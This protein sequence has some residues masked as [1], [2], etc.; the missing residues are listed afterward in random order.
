MGG[1][2][3]QHI[4]LGTADAIPRDKF[5]GVIQPPGPSIAIPTPKSSTNAA[6]QADKAWTNC[7]DATSPVLRRSGAIS[8]PCHGIPHRSARAAVST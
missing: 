1:T 8:R 7:S 4:M 6:F 2:A 5:Q 3:V